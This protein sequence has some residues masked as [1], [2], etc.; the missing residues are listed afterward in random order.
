MNDFL[1]T[2]ATSRCREEQ[3]WDSEGFFRPAGLRAVA[4]RLRF[5]M[6]R[7]SDVQL[8]YRAAPSA[9]IHHKNT[10]YTR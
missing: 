4:V 5:H 8:A 9:A 10:Q 3:K 7:C 6:A 2:W 1:P